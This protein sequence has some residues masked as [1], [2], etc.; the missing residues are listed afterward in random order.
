M[1]LAY[2]TRLAELGLIGRDGEFGDEDV[3]R[4]A[5]VAALERAG[6][7]VESVADLVHGGYFPLDFIDA[8]GNNAFAALGDATFGEES[9]RT[10]V[11]MDVLVAVR[12]AMG[13]LTP[14][15]EDR[16]RED[17]QAIVPLLAMQQELGFRPRAMERAIRVYGDSL[18]RITETES[19][20]WRT[21]I[22]EKM[23]AEGATEGDVGRFAGEISPRLSSL[24]DNAIVAMYHAQQR[25]AWLSNIVKGIARAGEKAGL[26]T[27]NEQPPAL[28]FLDI[29]GYTRL[30][31]EQG[32]TAAA[33][34]AERLNRIVHR[35]AVEHDGRPIKWLG[36]GVMLYFPNPARAVEAAVAVLRA[37]AGEDMPPAHVG[38][39]CGTVVFQEGDYYGQTVN[40]AARIGEY[41]RPGEILVS[42]DVAE[43]AAGS[44]ATFDEVG[45]IELK[46]VTG[47]V[48]L[49][50][51]RH[52]VT[53]AADDR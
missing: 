9:E 11:P 24:S 48:R 38:V 10:G 39:H 5:I 6:M 8:A 41:A 19:E 34:L 45:P 46:G 35:T 32:D 27:R 22:E 44:G 13:G 33:A 15:P 53:G 14:A 20:W 30:T 31:Q 18:R 25:L 40:M 37:L 49:F 1:S 29:T 50:S 7:P 42:A 43:A 2:V 51:V 52:P 16:M 36:D 47:E 12:E 3:R 21:E 28:C 26:H 4:I 17:E 23:M